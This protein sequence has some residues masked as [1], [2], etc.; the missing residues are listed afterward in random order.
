MI[1]DLH[2]LAEWFSQRT[3]LDAAEAVFVALS[4]AGQH[5]ISDRDKKGFYFWGVGNVIAV[6]MFGVLGRWMT[7]LLYVY[8]LWKC[9]TG[10]AKWSQLQANDGHPV[11]PRE[12]T[13][14]TLG[15]LIT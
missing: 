2:T 12:G 7:A 10:I 5:F 11:L 8:F 3:L 1:T 6:V 14:K 9:V 13:L 15:G 4:I